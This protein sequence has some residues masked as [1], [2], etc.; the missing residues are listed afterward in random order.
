MTVN[1][2]KLPLGVNDFAVIRNDNYLY[3]DKTEYLYK[4]LQNYYVT[5]LGRPHGFGKTLLL[6]TMENI[7]WGRRELFKGLWID[8]SD[9]DWTPNP[10]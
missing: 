6:S 9:Y 8:G 10:V 5:F 3:A 2:K 4:L 1:L 7:L